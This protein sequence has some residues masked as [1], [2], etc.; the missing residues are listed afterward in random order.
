MTDFMDQVFIYGTAWKEEA[1][2]DLVTEALYSGFCAIDTANQRKHYDEEAVGR[3]IQ[4]FL[5]K[6]GKKRSDLFLQTKF[7][8]AAGQ[9]HRIPYDPEASFKEQVF[10]SCESSLEHLQTDYLD[11]YLLHGP[12]YTTGFHTED[13]GVWNA[14]EE[15][16]DQKK[17]RALGIANVSLEQL[18]TLYKNSSVK[19]SYVQNRCFTQL[20]WDL[21]VRS[22]CQE[23]NIKYQG[24][25]LLT[26]NSRSV[27]REAVADIARKYH[28]TIP[29]II[30]RFC[31][32]LGMICLT[33]TKDKVHMKADLD[34]FSFTLTHDEM[35]VIENIGLDPVS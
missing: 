17:I 28:K 15:L 14:F 25:S 26:A 9:D 31:Y 12:M 32:Q 20:K 23:K 2:E 22:F 33:G 18:K 10:Q 27:Q 3:G 21:A 29:Q 11:S 35:H 34:I 30:F 24:F 19:P 13:M 8:Y 5:N 16:Y 7:T 1:T 6:S 4:S